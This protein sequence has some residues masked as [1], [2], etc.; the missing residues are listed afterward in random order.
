MWSHEWG[1][2]WEMSGDA[3]SCCR[4]QTG[5]HWAGVRIYQVHRQPRGLWRETGSSFRRNWATRSLSMLIKM[6]IL[7]FHHTNVRCVSMPML[8]NVTKCEENLSKAAT[9]SRSI[10][11]LIRG[12]LIGNYF[13]NRFIVSIIFKQ[14]FQTFNSSR[15]S[16]VRI[17]CFS[18][19]FVIV[20]GLSVD[21]GLAVKQN[22][23][24]HNIIFC[25]RLL[26]LE[27]SAVSWCFINQRIN[28]EK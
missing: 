17:C 18:C 12:K 10:G 16:Y 26:W 19:P 9:I 4:A 13:G 11:R 2:C 20:K 8:W 24:T 5:R 28:W 14:N 1:L 23:T 15:F 3:Q 7:A 22:T 27:L 6:L 25:C 21:F